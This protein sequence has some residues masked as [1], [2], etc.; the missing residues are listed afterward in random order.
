[1]SIGEKKVPRN[2]FFV[3][4]D[5]PFSRRTNKSSSRLV[6]LHQNIQSF[7][8]KINEL[9]IALLSFEERNMG[10]DII[11]L[12]ETFLSHDE[13]ELVNLTNYNL[14]ANYSRE[15]WRRGG[16]IIFCK[17][18]I[19]FESLDFTTD[20]TLE[21]E[22]E[23]CGIFIKSLHTAIFSFYRIPGANIFIFIEKLNKLLLN[24]SSQPK[25]FKNIIICGD[26][27]V[28]FS[29]EN[30]NKRRVNDILLR[31]NM[32]F[33]IKE[34]TRQG[35]CIDNFFSNIHTAIGSVHI[36]GLSDHETGQTLELEL[37]NTNNPIL[38]HFTY[39][40]DYCE[41]NIKKFI[42]CLSSLTFS[43][44]YSE[45]DTE[46][47]F[48]KMHDLL[49]LF[50][51]LCFPK[52]RVKLTNKTN[53]LLWIT[54]GIKQSCKNKRRLR[55]KYYKEKTR[56]NKGKFN[57][58]SKILKKC[59]IKSQKT[60][61]N[62]YI[63]NSENKCM[64]TW[65]V[66]N[67]TIGNIEKKH[68]IKEVI[69]KGHNISNGTEIAN[70][71]NNYFIKM[72]NVDNSLTQANPAAYIHSN[73]HS[74]FLEPTNNIEVLKIIMSLRNTNSVGYDLLSTGILKQVAQV[75]AHPIAHIAN[76]SLEQGIFPERLKC[77]IVKPLYKK[78]ATTDLN[79]YRPVTLIPILSKVL[80]KIY[81]IRLQSYLD[82]YNILTKQ[83]HGFR[84]NNSTTLASYNLLIKIL[85]NI[86]NRIPTVALFLD[87]SKAFDFVKHSILLQKLDKYGIRGQ[88]YDWIASYLND[89]KQIVRIRKLSESNRT[90]EDFDSDIKINKYG[91]P[92]GSILGPL[93]FLV[94]INDL[95]CSINHECI[96]FAD[97]TTIIVDGN[98]VDNF[99]NDINNALSDVI[100]WLDN[101]NLKINTNKTKY[102]QFRTIQ[103]QRITLNINHNNEKIE[104]SH[105]IKFLGLN[106]DE[107]INWKSQINVVCGKINKFVYALRKIKKV[108]SIKT[109]L[110]VYHSYVGSIIRYGIL[111]WGNS[112]DM[113]RAFIAQKKCIRAIWEMDQMESC[114]SIFKKH[115]IL[116][117]P[118]LYIL[119]SVMFVRSHYNLFEKQD[120][121]NRRTATQKPLIM[122]RPR[123]ELYKRNCAYM[124][125]KIY[126]NLPCFLLEKRGNMFNKALKEWLIDNCFYSID[127]FFE[128]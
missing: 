79:N 65:R 92:Q 113:R 56:K 54:K 60:Y 13:H 32:T 55:Y 47:A 26:F 109:A 53:K 3:N 99:E 115:K 90:I 80:E 9:E 105:I 127:E 6:I 87:M 107:N 62:K 31:N 28:E 81:Y 57:T 44:I 8:S 82:K 4:S 11:C 114:R 66:I 40:Y 125:C 75:I 41:E 48:N 29:T 38:Y 101:N 64:A 126:N 25:K 110:I 88:A 104:Q 89:R 83:Q 116:T 102:I 43:E 39:R 1:M 112:C 5:K 103:Q 76:L 69:E 10:I 106:L 86:N 30:I 122:P 96:L 17:K 85:N 72:T 12:S 20:I 70:S 121:S 120:N 78:G 118:S 119:E 24:L 98:G 42:N 50:N 33:H 18:H 71:F 35:K 117:L 108:T 91:V 97:D 73:I 84:K 93:L 111:L 59:I 68:D 61:N 46:A 128:I 51:G 21:T 67:N 19:E 123:L 7:L 15:K 14:A 74:M 49:M 100:L 58:Y 22:F 36:L 16:T 63:N 27:N 45:T 95:P 37:Q 23:I 77:S 124:T 94:Y 2:S 34:P 52:Y